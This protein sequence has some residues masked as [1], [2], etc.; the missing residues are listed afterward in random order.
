MKRHLNMNELF[1]SPSIHHRKQPHLIQQVPLNQNR[2]ISPIK[3][4]YSSSYTNLSEKDFHELR[5]A[6]QTIYHYTQSE[7]L[8]DHNQLLKQRLTSPYLHQRL[9]N[10]DQSSL[11]LYT[12]EYFIRNGLLNHNDGPT[13]HDNHFPSNHSKPV[14]HLR[15][16]L[17][18][19][20]S[21]ILTSPMNISLPLTLLSNQ[22]Y[23]FPALTSNFTLEK[24]RRSQSNM[25][26][27]I[28]ENETESMIVRRNKVQTWKK[29]NILQQRTSVQHAKQL[30]VSDY[31]QSSSVRT[32]STNIEENS[33]SLQTCNKEEGNEKPL[34]MKTT[35]DLFPMVKVLGRK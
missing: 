16:Y 11:P 31:H 26:L 34:E 33:S 22:K 17:S 35:E 15:S 29:E 14:I 21:M 8:C 12:N 23:L 18:S 5:H 32:L 13:I 7:I 4:T 6:L 1:L 3:S 25:E 20:S 9:H 10:D 2:S 30:D 24:F 19:S 27:S 28:N